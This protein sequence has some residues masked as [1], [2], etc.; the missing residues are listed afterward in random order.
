MIVLYTPGTGFPDLEVKIAY[1]LARVGIEAG[2]EVSIVP[3]VGFYEVNFSS[4]SHFSFLNKTFYLL[5]QRLLVNKKFYDLGVKARYKNKYL[6]FNVKGEYFKEHLLQ[7]DLINLYQSVRL[8]YFDFTKD[9][10]CRHEK[11]PKFGSERKDYKK[12]GG[13]I[14]LASVHAGKPQYRDNRKRDLNLGLCEA[15]GYLS[16]LGKESFSF[17]IQLG[18]GKNRKSVW[19]LPI[20][21]RKL[22]NKEII[23]LLSIQKTLHNFWLSDLLPLRTF[24]I[25]LLA[26][27][28]SL[29][30]II[31]ELDLSFHLSLVSKDN[32]GDTVIEQT[33]FV[34]AVPFS[35]FISNSPYNSV[36]LE[37]LLAGQP[38]IPS[39]IKIVDILENKKG[40]DLPTFARLYV[41]E[42][43]SENWVNLLYPETTKYLLKEV[44]MI[45][46]EIIKNK[47]VRAYAKTLGY[48]IWNKDYQN[49]SYADGIRNATTPDDVRKILEKLQREAKLRYDQEKTKDNGNPPHI[50]HPDDLELLNEIMQKSKENF[51]QVKTA[52]YLLAFSFESYKTLKVEKQEV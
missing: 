17:E 50:P 6:P 41:Q 31:E 14:L 8:K 25:G 48:F 38:K 49:Y 7:I 46:D 37:R 5:L 29:S 47:G 22:N 16:V 51:E 44:A 10:I 30:D 32:R 33:A 34:N 42:T 9:K 23:S 24:T 11:I 27:I 1:G 18:K 40:K 52:L 13:L 3:H 45:K 2:A 35:K 21:N 39:L 36:T 43:S 12:L 15:C 28:P 4:L 26:K 20:P 19:V